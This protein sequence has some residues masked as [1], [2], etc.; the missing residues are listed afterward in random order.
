[1]SHGGGFAPNVERHGGSEGDQTT[2][3]LWELWAKVAEA[4]KAY[5]EASREKERARVRLSDAHSEEERRGKVL[6]GLQVELTTA[7]GAPSPPVSHP[8]KPR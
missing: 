3:H 2:K 4:E 5:R 7:I 8:E 6:R 1:M